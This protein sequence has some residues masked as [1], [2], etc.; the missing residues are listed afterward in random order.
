MKTNIT[1]GRSP[2]DRR[3]LVKYIVFSARFCPTLFCHRHHRASRHHIACRSLLDFRLPIKITYSR[4]RH[5][6]EKTKEPFATGINQP[7]QNGTSTWH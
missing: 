4:C 3:P 6:C 7:P 5:M 2:I 1:Q